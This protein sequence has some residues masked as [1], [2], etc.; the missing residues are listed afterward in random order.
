MPNYTYEKCLAN[1][2]RINWRIE[3]VIGGQQFDTSRR[4]L[5]AQ[6]SGADAIGFLNETEK[7]KLTHVEMGAYAHLFGFVEEFITPTILRLAGEFE[8]DQRPAFDA[9]TNFA[10]EEVKRMTL[11][12]EVRAMVNETIGF[13]ATLLGD[14]KAVAHLVMSKNIGA[15]LLLT[16]VIEWFTQQHY[17][18]GFKDDE[19][20]DPFTKRIFRAHWQEESQHAQL[21]YLETVRKFA[22][23]TAAEKDQAIDDLIELV[24]ALDGLLQQQTAHDVDNLARYLDR[25]FTEAEHE[26]VANSV[27]KAKRYTFI[28]SGVT[29]P[30]FQLVFTEVTNE[31]QREKVGAALGALLGEAAPVAARAGPRRKEK[32]RRPVLE[33]EFL[34]FEGC[35]HHQTARRL[36]DETIAEIGSDTTVQDICVADHEQAL[37]L[38]FQGSPTIR[39]DGQDVQP[40]TQEEAPYGRACRIYQTPDGAQ[41]S[42][43]KAMIR[44]TLEAT[45]HA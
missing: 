28:E 35:P 38:R 2:Y 40:M 19:S 42:P 14:E 37:R 7:T 34:W 43:T 36:L 3:E 33:I 11:F 5:P 1:S 26:E 4:W 32:R 31:A 30:N 25:R 41:G 45:P 18:S 21:D 9:L 44:A 6:L 27:L 22:E 16:S 39:I 17:L 10:A 23:M 13:P 8:I 20:L 15:V 24:G 29:H 12:R